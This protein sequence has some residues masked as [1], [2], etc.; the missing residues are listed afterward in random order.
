MVLSESLAILIGSQGR[1]DSAR[2][3]QVLQLQGEEQYELAL[4]LLKQT[5][6]SI[7]RIPAEKLTETSSLQQVGFDSLLSAELR[8]ALN[9]EFSID[10]P[11]LTLQ[12]SS[13]S[14]LARQL[15]SQLES[16]AGPAT[17]IDVEDMSEEELDRLLLELGSP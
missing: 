13:L 5:V 9:I 1:S 15:C 16:A 7:V 11:G 3:E 8:N 14:E 17:E 2:R 4:Q 10:F 6:A 12:N